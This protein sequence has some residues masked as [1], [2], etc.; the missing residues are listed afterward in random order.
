MKR[1]KILLL[2][3][4]YLIFIM[5]LSA[6]IFDFSNHFSSVQVES[7]V[8]YGTAYEIEYE[9]TYSNNY[10]EEIQWNM[11][12]LWFVGIFF[13][14]APKKPL[15]SNAMFFNFDF[16]M[17]IPSKTGVMED[18]RWTDISNPNLVTS[19]YSHDNEIAGAF[20]VNGVGGLS[21]PLAGNFLAKVSLDFMIIYNCFE[22]RDSTQQSF[23]S[24]DIIREYY[25][26]WAA[27]NPVFGIEWHR[28]KFILKTA[29]SVNTRFLG[30]AHDRKPS[31]YLEN[32]IKKGLLLEAKGSFFYNIDDYFRVGISLAYTSID[33]RGD[34]TYKYSW[35][36]NKE[37][38]NGGGIGYKA[39]TGGLMLGIVF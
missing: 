35:L 11:K 15:V 13:E 29:F 37:V 31:T 27:I 2:V 23:L 18:R 12:P 4:L 19:F 36:P 24:N 7:G 39:F 17:G 38:S 26:I 8:L 33:S 34:L 10:V 16:K 21:I 32:E 1:K 6:Y 3:F 9:N 14:Y 5:P 22:I 25:Q 28:D 30:T 20:T